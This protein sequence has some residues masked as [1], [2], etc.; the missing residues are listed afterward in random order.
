MLFDN[1]SFKRPCDVFPRGHTINRIRGADVN[2]F[3]TDWKDPVSWL[4]TRLA[5]RQ[6]QVIDGVFHRREISAQHDVTFHQGVATYKI[7]S[8][9]PDELR[10]D[11][12]SPEAFAKLLND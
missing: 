7:V 11:L 1:L 9:V 6:Q 8:S 5:H 10:N 12:P 2:S 4:R 3:G